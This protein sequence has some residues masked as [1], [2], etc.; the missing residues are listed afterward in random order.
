[1]SCPL[2]GAENSS[3]T[4]SA[5]SPSQG[6]SAKAAEQRTDR[7]PQDDTAPERDRPGKSL[8]PL[9][10]ELRVKLEKSPD[11]GESMCADDRARTLYEAPVQPKAEPPDV[12]AKLPGDVRIKVEPDSKEKADR[13]E[14]VELGPGPSQ[15]GPLREGHSD[16]D[17]SA[18]C[19]A[20]EDVDGEPD[21]QR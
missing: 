3:D 10:N 7:A 17:S 2:P 19:S 5:P 4:E 20:D 1:M 6:D 14:L 21:R 12:D 13:A 11:A 18:T 16:N 9:Y 15:R 8:E